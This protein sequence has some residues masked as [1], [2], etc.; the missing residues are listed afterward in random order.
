MNVVSIEHKR[1]L[2]SPSPCD[3]SHSTNNTC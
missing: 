3:P 1:E 2:S